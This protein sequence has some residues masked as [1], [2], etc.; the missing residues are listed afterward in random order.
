MLA[1]LQ[2]ERERELDCVFFQGIKRLYADMHDINVDVPA[3]YS[4]LDTLANKLHSK[5]VLGDGLMKELPSR[6]LLHKCR[7]S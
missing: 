7:E 6:Y 2:K 3:A 1:N 4:L 5:H